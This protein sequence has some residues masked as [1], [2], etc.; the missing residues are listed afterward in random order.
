[1]STLLAICWKDLR[2]LL[3]DRAGLF[4]TF[5]F[6]VVYALF[7]G[8]IFSSGG[9]EAERRIPLRLVDLDGGPAAAAFLDSLAARPGLD[10][11]RDSLAGAE[12]AVRRGRATAALIVKPGF[13]RGQE[14][15]FGGQ[16]PEVELLHDPTRRAEAGLLQG[17]LMEQ[18]FK[19][20][21][22]RFRDTRSFLPEVRA[23]RDSLAAP[24]ARRPEL[25]YLRR[26]TGELELFLGRQAV[27]E[28]LAQARPDTGAGRRDGFLAGWEPLRVTPRE[29]RAVREG[30]QSSFEVSFPQGL[31]WGVISVAA[32]FGISLVVERKEGTLRRLRAAPLRRRQILAGKALACFLA[33]VALCLL[34]L[35]LGLPFGVRAERPLLLLAAIPSIALAFTGLMLLV[36]VLGRTERAV[37]GI[38]WSLMT[39]LAMLGGG[40]VPLFFMPEWMRT[41]GHVSPVKWAILALEGA[42]WRGFGWAELLPVCGILAAFGLGTA[43]VG[44]RAFR[45]SD[46]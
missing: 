8:S 24:A 27:A 23:W 17:I 14:H 3:R 44:L 46:S 42:L 15:L 13:G 25:D 41:L 12:N 2:L 20:L 9:D 11:R 26:W 38:G 22:G 16:A 34:L 29:L 31:L 1:M 39:F 19:G 32:S 30:P 21:E 28:S 4:F 45:W 40:M 18:A 35:L 10:A 7:F 33:V 43:L 5:V 36:S 37:S 6:P